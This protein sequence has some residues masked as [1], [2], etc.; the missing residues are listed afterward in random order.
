MV[1]IIAVLAAALLSQAR[2]LQVGMAQEIMEDTTGL[3][4]KDL[5][6][7]YEQFVSAA[8]T[9]ADLMGNYEDIEREQRRRQLDE[10]LNAVLRKNPLLVTLY[11]VW[12]PGVLDGL[13]DMYRNTPGSDETGNFVPSYS[14]ESGKI[15]L[16]AMTGYDALLKNL[17]QQVFVGDP[18]PR[19]IQGETIITVQIQV[20]II[21]TRYEVVGIVGVEVDMSYSQ[22]LVGTITPYNVGKAELY[23]T[24]GTILASYEKANVGL[25]FQEVKLDRLGA[26]GL[27]VIENSLELQEPAHFSYEGNL[28]QAY[29]FHL[30]DSPDPWLLITSVPLDT[31]L[32]KV[33][34]MTLFAVYLTL[35]AIVLSAAAG[36]I[37]AARLAKPIAEVSWTLK[38]ISEGEGDLTK[39]ITSKR[40]D[41]VGDLAHYF[42]LTLK[43]IRDLVATIKEQSTAL[44]GTGAELS[45]N[46]EETATAINEITANIQTINGMVIRQSS[47]ITETNAAMEQITLG[48]HKLNEQVE[49]QTDSMAQS[50]SAI[51][52][53]LANIQ[54]VTATLVKN[55]DNM[56]ELIE[57]SD[58]G[59]GGLQEVVADTR[60]IARES[61]GLLEINTVMENI[62]S[63]TDLLSMNAA[64]E[65]AHAGEAGK[66]FAV[67]AGEI[68]KLAE[69]SGEQSKTISLVLKK[70]KGSIDKITKSTSSV[71]NRFEAIDNGVRTVS[72]QEHSIRNAMEEQSAGS[73][74]ILEAISRLK[75]ITRQVKEDAN[76]MLGR[77]GE[78]TQESKNLE[79]MT[80]ELSG[81]MNEMAVG[82]DEINS[83]M[84]QVNEICGRNRENIT[85]LAQE[86]SRFKIE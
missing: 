33:N 3:Y 59:R 73:R 1:I 19:N 61:E 45:A 70:I 75:D 40:K 68:R 81:G 49:Y 79:Q 31:V 30:G 13:D 25:R 28:F 55:S 5:E 42:N 56:R 76:A 35:G 17:P 8:S 11:T 2:K 29:P 37:A 67:V 4:A 77:S 7:Y 47:G 23:S 57:A 52:E 86:V 44:S 78:V 48:I 43:K 22:T 74:Q 9:L 60:E 69:S 82:A 10:D 26:A 12:K 14:H 66:G 41:E 36:L 85:I 53:M 6:A 51:E 16:K 84:N 62:A 63:Q 32:E 18:A 80:A 71:L 21:N 65:A 34:G 83:A 64:I 38:D 58:A 72:D 20:P 50:S 24:N 15:E 39:S 46:T 54:S 27:R